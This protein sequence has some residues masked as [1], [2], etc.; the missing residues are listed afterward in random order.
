MLLV[1]IAILL[2]LMLIFFSSLVTL[3]IIPSKGDLK[4]QLHLASGFEDF[5][6]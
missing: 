4:V 3:I 2:V 6:L 1:A 5:S